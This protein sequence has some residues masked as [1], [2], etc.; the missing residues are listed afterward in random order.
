MRDG[1][2]DPGNNIRDLGINN[3]DAMQQANATERAAFE[4]RKIREALEKDRVLNEAN[5]AAASAAQA[6]T[7]DGRAKKVTARILLVVSVLIGL[8]STVASNTMPIEW[9]AYLW[10]SWPVLVVLVLVS[11]VLLRWQ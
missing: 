11:I 9:R 7:Q 8:A 5:Q 6:N 2:D 4:L 1:N 3:L 10:I